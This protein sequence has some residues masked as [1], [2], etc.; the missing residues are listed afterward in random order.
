MSTAIPGMQHFPDIAAGRSASSSSVPVT[1]LLLLTSKD[2]LPA[3][4]TKL[5]KNHANKRCGLH[6]H[7]HHTHGLFLCVQRDPSLPPLTGVSL[8]CDEHA[9]PIAPGYVRVERTPSGRWA[10]LKDEKDGKRMFLCLR[11]GGSSPP[12]VDI[13]FV[14]PTKQENFSSSTL[15]NYV[16]VSRSTAGRDVRIAAAKGGG[17]LILCYRQRVLQLGTLAST[18]P[19]LGAALSALY[20]R[21]QTVV[22]HCLKTLQSIAKSPELFPTESTES[23]NSKDSM[24]ILLK[25]FHAHNQKG[26]KNLKII[27]VKKNYNLKSNLLLGLL[28][29]KITLKKVG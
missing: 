15:D 16:M 24:E 6:A 13:D 1:D 2:P 12:I 25:F 20:T 29:H 28:S 8:T 18:M 21:E 5:E 23:K 27:K 4:Y 19:H 14:V 17:A 11:R 22:E 9:E 10:G 3:G 7:D 26:L